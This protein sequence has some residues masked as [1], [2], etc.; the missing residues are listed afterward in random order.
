MGHPAPPFD[1]LGAVPHPDRGIGPR[2]FALPGHHVRMERTRLPCHA[3]KETRGIASHRV[4]A[5]EELQ[6]GILGSD[7]EESLNDVL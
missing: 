2:P 6:C 3:E 5:R 4:A 1:T 7:R